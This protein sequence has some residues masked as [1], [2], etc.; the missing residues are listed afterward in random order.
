MMYGKL[1]NL[2]IL[3]TYNTVHLNDYTCLM[4]SEIAFGFFRIG[5]VFKIRIGSDSD[6][7]ISD[8]IRILKFTN[9][10]IGNFQSDPM[11]TFSVGVMLNGNFYEYK[12]LLVDDTQRTRLEG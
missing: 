3:E 4:P 7:I 2:D 5:M 8:R 10:R 12:L 11:H 1:V 9:Y 6:W